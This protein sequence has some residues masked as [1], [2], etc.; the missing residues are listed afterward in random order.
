MATR[1]KHTPTFKKKV[2]I[3]ALSDELTLAQ[4]SAKHGVHSSQVKAWKDI[5][6]RDSDRLFERKNAAKSKAATH[7]NQQVDDLLRMV[8]KLQMELEYLKKKLS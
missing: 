4:L 3:A 5:L 7:S 1:K 2:A 8:G 6:L